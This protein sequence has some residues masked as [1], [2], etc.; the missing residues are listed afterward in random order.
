MYIQMY[1]PNCDVKVKYS[2]IAVCIF[3]LSVIAH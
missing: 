2:L 1:A 3:C